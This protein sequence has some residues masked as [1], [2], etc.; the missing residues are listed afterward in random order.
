MRE[1]YNLAIRLMVFALAAALL[2]A[3]V[4]A[5]TADKIAE[6]TREKIN[7]ARREVI[8]EYDF[9]DAGAD[10]TGM[11]YVTGVY[12]A[13]DGENCAGYVYELESRG[14]GGTVYLCAGISPDGIVTGVKVSAHVETKGLGTD[15][16][17]KFMGSF[18][19]MEAA[20][21]NAMGVDAMSGATVS[22]NA[23]RNAVDEALEHFEENY[24]GGEAVQ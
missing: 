5:L 16:E 9:A 22:S 13:M 7:A 11:D 6:N 12:L 1:T 19:G 3:V 4:N 8:G 10:V 21:G 14:Y 18:V 2:L 23:V 20:A 17:K 15:A 24:A